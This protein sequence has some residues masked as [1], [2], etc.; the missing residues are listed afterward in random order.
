M[1]RVKL[2]DKIDRTLIR[3]ALI[4]VLPCIHVGIIQ[5]QDK[6]S[7]FLNQVKLTES[8]ISSLEVDYVVFAANYSSPDM[9]SSEV[10]LRY[11]KNG[12]RNKQMLFLKAGKSR[13]MVLMDDSVWH[14]KQGKFVISSCNS[15]QAIVLQKLLIPYLIQVHK[16]LD[17]SLFTMTEILSDSVLKIDVNRR[18][19]QLITKFDNDSESYIHYTYSY[20]E[21]NILTSFVRN[22]Y[23]SSM[24]AFWYDS[25]VVQELRINTLTTEDLLKSE[26]KMLSRLDSVK[27]NVAIFHKA[28]DS[29]DKRSSYYLPSIGDYFDFRDLKPL[30]QMNED[31]FLSD[32]PILITYWYAGCGPCRLAH[33]K[34]KELYSSESFNWLSVNTKDSLS[35]IES[36]V[37][38]GDYPFAV[39]RQNFTNTEG[40]RGVPLILILDKNKRVLYADVGFGPVTIHEIEQVLKR[41]KDL[42]SE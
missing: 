40:P 39:Y 1:G 36:Y 41:T 4:I 23:S 29:A 7:E 25:V 38:D 37:I 2:K 11:L 12:Y 6:G 22:S 13:E 15:P 16:P 5:A 34:I 27:S 9:D 24:D 32:G 19:V 35:K 3:T 20:D 14:F 26:S 18:Q 10:S 42:G 30:V 28:T 33:R 31:S 21:R 8:L 17:K